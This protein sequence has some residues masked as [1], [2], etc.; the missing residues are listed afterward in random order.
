MFLR[1]QCSYTR[2]FHSSCVVVYL[3]IF[4]CCNAY[5]SWIRC[6]DGDERILMICVVVLI[7]KYNDFMN[8]N[9]Q[10]NEKMSA[11]VM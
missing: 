10:E 1:T 11:T 7:S 5:H 4:Y 8:R 6:G 3:F 9:V 2:Y